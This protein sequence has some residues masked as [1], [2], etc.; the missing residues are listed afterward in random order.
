MKKG[1]IVSKQKRVR[2]VKDLSLRKLIKQGNTYATLPPTTSS[3]SWTLK[4][5]LMAGT[6]SSQECSEGSCKPFVE[7]AT[8]PSQSLKIQ[9]DASTET[10]G[11]KLLNG[12]IKGIIV[13]ALLAVPTAFLYMLYTVVWNLMTPHYP[14]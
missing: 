4:Q 10:T 12:A 1:K 5:A 9:P 8:Q 14:K 3:Q 11:Y 13:A 2:P 7:F 6:T